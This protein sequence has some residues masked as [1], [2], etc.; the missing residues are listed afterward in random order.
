LRRTAR[1]FDLTLVR[2]RRGIDIDTADRRLS[3]AFHLDRHADGPGAL[4][5]LVEA[6]GADL[7]ARL[8][9]VPQLH[10][11]VTDAAEREPR[12][13]KR[14]DRCCTV[15][16]RETCSRDSQS[17]QRT[18]A[19]FYSIRRVTYLRADA[20]HSARV[21]VE[22]LID[23]PAVSL[24]IW[25]GQPSIHRRT[26]CWAS[27]QPNA[28]THACRFNSQASLSRSLSLKFAR[29][30]APSLGRGLW[31]SDQR[32]CSGYFARVGDRRPPFPAG[33]VGPFPLPRICTGY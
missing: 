29:L 32:V 4:G 33:W 23:A 30:A 16:S 8:E 11:L 2:Q 3:G 31:I 27:L 10:R 20:L 5:V 14:R 21:D 28:I 17:R 18:S 7:N 24:A 9:D 13:R 22:L 1:D 19:F 15:P 25:I 6:A 12:H 26:S